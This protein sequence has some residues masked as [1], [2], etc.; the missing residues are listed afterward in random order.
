MQWAS[1]EDVQ[2]QVKDALTRLSPNVRDD[3][4]PVCDALLLGN[5]RDDVEE[6][7]ELV[8]VR[9]GQVM[10]G[11]HMTLRYHQ[12]VGRSTGIDVA[13]RERAVRFQYF[14]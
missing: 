4:V 11:R 8:A 5:L 7:G 2:M 13:E 1:A 12:D 14:L 9:Q 6:V 10:S 3:P